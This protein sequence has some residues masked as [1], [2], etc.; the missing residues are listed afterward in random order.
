MGLKNKMP[1]GEVFGKG[2]GLETVDFRVGYQGETEFPTLFISF[3]C[4]EFV[5][6]YQQLSVYINKIKNKTKIM[7]AA[8]N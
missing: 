8:C 7:T 1:A 2:H 3:A 5:S 4:H 6:I